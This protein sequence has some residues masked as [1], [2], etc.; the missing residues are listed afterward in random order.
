ME[1]F[2]FYIPFEEIFRQI[3]HPD[4]AKFYKQESDP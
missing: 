1:V 2:Y 3:L 4:F